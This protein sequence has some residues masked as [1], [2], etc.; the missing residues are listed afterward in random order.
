MDARNDLLLSIDLRNKNTN[1]IRPIV[2]G[3]C[4]SKNPRDVLM[5][6]DGSNAKN[7]ADN[8]PTVLPPMSLPKKYITRTDNTP[9]T[10]GIIAQS[11]IKSTFAPNAVMTSYMAAPVMGIDGNAVDMS[12]P[13]GYQS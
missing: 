12:S 1:N 9:I 10:G 13:N 3:T 4:V 2:P 6:I 8:K 7:N 5:M 11:V